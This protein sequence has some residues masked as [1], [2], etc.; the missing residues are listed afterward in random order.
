MARNVTLAPLQA[1]GFAL[2]DAPRA[3]ALVNALAEVGLAVVNAGG[4]SGAGIEFR[5]VHLALNLGGQRVKLGAQLLALLRSDVAVGLEAAFALLN[6]TVTAH[7]IS[8]L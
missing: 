8:R 3:D 2:V 5:V 4:R 7:Q 1:V 6:I